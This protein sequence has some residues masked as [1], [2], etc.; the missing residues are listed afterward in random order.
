MLARPRAPVTAD[1][2]PCWTP[3][4]GQ[5]EV[6]LPEASPGAAASRVRRTRS[7]PT[8]L[9]WRL[10]ATWGGIC[11]CLRAACKLGPRCV[12]ARG[13][14]TGSDWAG[15]TCQH[16]GADACGFSIPRT[17]HHNGQQRQL[18]YSLWFVCVFVVVLCSMRSSQH[19]VFHWPLVRG[20]TSVK[21]LL[22]SLRGALENSEEL[23]TDFRDSVLPN[24]LQFSSIWCSIFGSRSWVVSGQQVIQ[25]KH[26]SSLLMNQDRLLFLGA[27]T[28]TFCA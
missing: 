18:A 8:G 3:R 6:R 4:G 9:R 7:V 22:E 12:A 13:S 10:P 2:K 19:M 28:I 15:S 23:H 26:H 25:S 11:H 5:F 16:I 17:L 21:T 14:S 1:P 20:G 27:S 24:S